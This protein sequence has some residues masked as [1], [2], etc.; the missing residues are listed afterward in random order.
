MNKYILIIL[1]MSLVTTLPRITP[2]LFHKFKIPEPV[3]K[4]M[5]GIPY[6]ALAALTIP[7]VFYLD[8]SRSIVG[9]TG[10]IVAVLLSLLKIP[11]YIIILASV[12]SVYAIYLII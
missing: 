3:E 10:F 9:I 7:G 2:L 8:S 11:L 1:G 5:K 6:A 4:W 12:L